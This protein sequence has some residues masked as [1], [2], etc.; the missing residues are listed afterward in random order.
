MT[1]IC[2]NDLNKPIEIPNSK[3]I[4]KNNIYTVIE[5]QRLLSSNQIGY[6]LEEI[7]LDE[8]CFPYHYFL[9]TRFAICDDIPMNDLLEEV[10][11]IL[12]KELKPDEK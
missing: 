6:V 10:N 3:W 12:D 11:T 8:S 4:K 9:A 1:V 7:I 5:V 2:I